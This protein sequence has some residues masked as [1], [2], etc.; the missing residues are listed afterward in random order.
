MY[1]NT[2]FTPAKIE[3]NKTNIINRGPG[4]RINSKAAK[5][6]QLPNIID[7]IIMAGNDV[8]SLLRREEKLLSL[9]KGVNV[10]N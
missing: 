8:S 1:Q 10:K 2:N 4:R 7:N 5:D 6:P 3:R 9:Q